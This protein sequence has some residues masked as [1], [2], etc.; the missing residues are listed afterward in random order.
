LLKLGNLSAASISGW[1]DLQFHEQL[2]LQKGPFH[3][4]NA[5]WSKSL[6]SPATLMHTYLSHQM[7]WSHLRVNIASQ[8]LDGRRRRIFRMRGVISRQMDEFICLGT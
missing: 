7:D 2:V 1:I 3:S 8:G 6:P 4:S 5:C